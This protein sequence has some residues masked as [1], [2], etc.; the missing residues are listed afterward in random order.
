[1]EKKEEKNFEELIEEL[2]EITTQLENDK[3]TLDDSVKLFEKGMN[4]S[5]DCN[6]RLENAE[7]RITI[8]LNTEDGEIK[9]ENFVPN[10]GE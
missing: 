4:I 6:E 5:K 9:E 1:M 7:K 8:L 3:L 10:D 2:E